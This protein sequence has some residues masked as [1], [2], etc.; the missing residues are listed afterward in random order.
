M[1]TLSHYLLIS[2]FIYKSVKYFDNLL[3]QVYF[4]CTARRTPRTPTSRSRTRTPSWRWSRR[5]TRWGRRCRRTI[6]RSRPEPW[7][8]LP[9]TIIQDPSRGQ[10]PNTLCTPRPVLQIRSEANQHQSCQLNAI[11]ALKLQRTYQTRTFRNIFILK[12][13]WLHHYLTFDILSAFFRNYWNVL[14]LFS[15]NSF[16]YFYKNEICCLSLLCQPMWCISK[17]TLS[18]FS[19]PQ[20]ITT[21]TQKYYLA[22]KIRTWFNLLIKTLKIAGETT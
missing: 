3:T 6:I 22:A 2:N 1:K 16:F 5:L 19:L 7:S 13:K 15:W 18:L 8:C 17:K 11:I 9:V 4:S 14:F 20:L 10:L 21:N 12:Q